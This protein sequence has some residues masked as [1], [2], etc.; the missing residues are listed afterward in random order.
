MQPIDTSALFNYNTLKDDSGVGAAANLSFVTATKVLTITDVSVLPAA[1]PFV[2]MLVDVYDRQ[3]NSK[4]AR[5]AAAA[6]NVA[7]DLDAAVS[8]DMT[9]PFSI[10][11]KLVTTKG[12][13]KNGG[14]YDMPTNA[15]IAATPIQ[16][17]K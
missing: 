5:I 4:S 12:F 9:G 8:L 15:D 1:D 7:I 16:F 6:G 13:E 10:K 2:A 11:V 17:E 14:Y 3:G